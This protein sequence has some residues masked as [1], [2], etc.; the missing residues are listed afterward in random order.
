MQKDPWRQV[1]GEDLWKVLRMCSST[2]QKVLCKSG[3]SGS[4]LA[5]AWCRGRPPLHHDFR[6]AS[7]GRATGGPPQGSPP[8][9]LKGCSCKA[10][11]LKRSEQL[12]VPTLMGSGVKHWGSFQSLNKKLTVG[13]RRD[14]L[15]SLGKDNHI[16]GEFNIFIAY[17]LKPWVLISDW[18]LM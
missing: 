7:P 3:P 4:Y 2:L 1:Q 10:C 6:P 17:W 11:D 14:N 9:V 16:P 8:R 12:I 18:I 5:G 15:G 13:L